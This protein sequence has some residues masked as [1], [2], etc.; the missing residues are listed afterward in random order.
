MTGK[1]ELNQDKS[2]NKDLSAPEPN[3]SPGPAPAQAETKQ[4]PLI[5]THNVSGSASEKRGTRD[6]STVIIAVIILVV[7][8]C[9]IAAGVIFALTGVI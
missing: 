6:S 4:E 8:F 7:L 1:D 9:V 5:N 3:A 2:C